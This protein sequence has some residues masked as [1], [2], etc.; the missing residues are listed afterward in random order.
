MYLA[1][2]SIEIIDFEIIII[3]S[4]EKCGKID[5]KERKTTKQEQKNTK[6]ENGKTEVAIKCKR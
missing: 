5:S 4:S 6:I 3:D 2:K 1:N